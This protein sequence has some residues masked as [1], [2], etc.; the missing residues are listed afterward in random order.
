M[1]W[2]YLDTIMDEVEPSW[3][4]ELVFQLIITQFFSMDKMVKLISQFYEQS[5][6]AGKVT[7][8]QLLS[9][10]SPQIGKQI[11]ENYKISNQYNTQKDFQ[12]IKDIQS[13]NKVLMEALLNAYRF[14]LLDSKH[15]SKQYFNL[16]AQVTK[17][18]LANVEML[19]L[20]VSD[21]YDLPLIW[22]DQSGIGEYFDDVICSNSY[23]IPNY[24]QYDQGSEKHQGIIY[25]LETIHE[26]A[27]SGEKARAAE[28]ATIEF[29]DWINDLVNRG[30]DFESSI[31]LMNLNH[32]YLVSL[33]E[34]LDLFELIDQY[35]EILDHLMGNHVVIREFIGSYF[36]DRQIQEKIYLNTK[37]SLIIN[38][39]QREKHQKLINLLTQGQFWTS[40][41]AEWQSFSEEFELTNGDWMLYAKTACKGKDLP[42]ARSILKT[43]LD[44]NYD[45]EKL[46]GLKGQIAYLEE[47]YGEAKICLKEAVKYYPEEAEAW[48]YL[49]KVYEI[50]GDHENALSSLKSGIF[51]TPDNADLY[52]NL[53]QLYLKTQ[54]YS[55]ALKHLRKAVVLNQ[56]NPEHYYPLIS[57]LQ[58][59]GLWEEALEYLLLARR[60]WPSERKFAYLD[61]IRLL[62]EGKRKE[63]ITVLKIA[64]DGNPE[65]IPSEWYLLLVETIL[66]DEKQTW[67]LA[68]NY[69]TTTEQLLI[70]QKTL[71]SLISQKEKESSS[72]I[73]VLLAEVY[74]LLEEYEHSKSLFEKIFAENKTNIHHAE[75][76]WRVYAGLGMVRSIHKQFEEA[77]VLIGQ[78]SKLNNANLAIKRKLAD[79]YYL[80]NLPEE[81]L[82]VA[83]EIFNNRRDDL[84]NILW[85]ADFAKKINRPLERI[86]ALEEALHFSK[87]NAKINNQLAV[88]YILQGKEDEAAH[89]L[90]DI[91][92]D[93]DASFYDFRTAVTTFLRM[94]KI[95]EA[96]GFYI[97]GL[98][99][100][101]GKSNLETKTELI[102]L[103]YLNKEW[104]QV[105]KLVTA[106]DFEGC[107]YTVYHVIQAQAYQNLNQMDASITSYKQA[108]DLNNGLGELLIQNSET[109]VFIPENWIKDFENKAIDKSGIG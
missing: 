49:S 21:Q 45:T 40:A 94:D 44:S 15:Q 5:E 48:V 54:S 93:Q 34:K 95:K 13:A 3:A 35:L 85:F 31:F 58:T 75:F 89:V 22:K 78:A 68:D 6:I 14:L 8:L 19:R 83:N 91:S 61:A 65:N 43:L 108:L 42:V 67:L 97:E 99:R 98:E 59:V 92:K 20:G 24:E 69:H 76:G 36:E 74:F 56:Y 73:E 63:A 57:T 39:D 103:Y 77:L 64:T 62:E 55:E 30:I 2:I 46:S 60:E 82:K 52:F 66:F 47:N 33:L 80:A 88:E 41:L 104:D 29:R 101:S 9:V 72:V 11:V 7:W 25:R 27:L 53:A 100:I 37:K 26:I 81:A 106:E 4:I 18:M 84:N 28:L 32:A 17:K 16:A 51:A 38:P 10:K 1:I 86:E 50:D 71:Q 96:L 23:K 102:Y 79:V 87:Y 90:E 109:P 70:S 107:D 105:L 12:N